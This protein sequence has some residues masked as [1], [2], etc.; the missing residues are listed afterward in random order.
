MY[1]VYEITDSLEIFIQG[2][3]TKEEAVEKADRLHKDWAF[4]GQDRHFKVMYY[5][6][7]VYQ[8]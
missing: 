5:Y 8:N 4:Q 2:F 6:Y 3:N 1:H 7:R